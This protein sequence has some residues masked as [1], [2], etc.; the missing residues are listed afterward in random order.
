MG[1]VKE[2]RRILLAPYEV[3][4]LL[5]ELLCQHVK[6]SSF[7]DD[8]RILYHRTRP[9]VVAVRKTIKLVEAAIRGHEFRHGA[10]MPLSDT[11]SSVTR[12]PQHLRQG[13]LAVW[14]ADIIPGH[15]HLGH[16]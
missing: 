2:E 1:E 14:N 15:E 5:G 9:H 13:G 6:V 8:T 11:R 4:G 10:D 7:F 12:A 3:H 16:T